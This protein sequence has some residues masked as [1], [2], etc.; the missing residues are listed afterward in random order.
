MNNGVLKSKGGGVACYINKE[1]HLDCH[2][3]P[4][5]TIANCDIKLLTLRSVYSYGKK[6]YI[7]ALYRPPDGSVEVFCDILSSFI[8]DGALT[9]K[10]LWI[11]GDYNIDFL[12]RADNKTKM[13]REVRRASLGL[14]DNTK[15]IAV[16]ET[17]SNI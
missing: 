10:E 8:E 15:L 3:M 5:L 7:M 13:D 1:L 9:D 16:I 11:F 6:M 2:I 4:G 12:K 17:V 14:C